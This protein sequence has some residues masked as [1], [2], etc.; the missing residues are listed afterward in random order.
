M[1]VWVGSDSVPDCV[2]ACR[3]ALLSSVKALTSIL[4]PLQC[5]ADQG[6]PQKELNERK[7]P[8]LDRQ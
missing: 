5:K 7:N 8:R 3:Q 6:P 1:V 2:S 4:G